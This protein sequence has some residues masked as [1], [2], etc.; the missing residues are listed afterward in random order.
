MT[1][2]DTIQPGDAE[3]PVRGDGSPNLR[4][5]LL[6]LS[7]ILLAICSMS[8]IVLNLIHSVIRNDLR[9]VLSAVASSTS[10]EFQRQAAEKIRQVESLAGSTSVREAVSR[11]L[12][13]DPARSQPEKDTAEL[14]NLL[15]GM[16]GTGRFA[17]FCVVAADGSILARSGALSAAES[18]FRQLLPAYRKTNQ[19]GAG[20][21]VLLDGNEGESLFIAAA[22][23]TDNQDQYLGWLVFFNRPAAELSTIIA[24]N[25]LGPDGAVF[26]FDRGGRLLAAGLYDQA[27]GEN[28]HPGWAASGNPAA[29]AAG[30]GPYAAAGASGR[31]GE[32]ISLDLDGYTGIRGTE[33][34]GA[35]TW[36][37]SPGVGVAVELDLAAAYQ[38]YRWI[39]LLVLTAFGLSV[40][41]FVVLLA[42][43]AGSRQ[44]ALARAEQAVV[45]NERLQQEIELRGKLEKIIQENDEYIRS[46]VSSIMDGVITTDSSGRIE[47]LNPRAEK[48]FGY[49]DFELAG[50]KLSVLAAS[51]YSR[52]LTQRLGRYARDGKASF[53]GKAIE[54][55]G[56]RKSGKTFPVE[57]SVA[58]MKLAG[59]G[60]LVA[61]ARDITKHKRLEKKLREQSSLDGLTR[62]A[63][64]RT[65]DSTLAHE[66]KRASR[67]GLPLGLIML[68]IDFFK[69]YNDSL[70]HQAGDQCLRQV[71]AV[72]DK[73]VRRPGDLAARYGGEE[74]VALLPETSPRGTSY[75]AEKIRE[76]VEAL[77]MVHPASQVSA[78][79][80]VSLGEVNFVPQ[81][82]QDSSVLVSAADQ[83]LYE[84]KHNGRNRVIRARE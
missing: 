59:T 28:P 66:W 53:I 57:L 37:P 79:V 83:A 70:G 80:T 81:R 84:A 20:R 29:T 69:N 78:V 33:V 18:A 73:L 11:S 56:R 60:K 25:P 75:L 23:L 14:E 46:V 26:F 49:R 10:S 27:A 76:Q 58:E 74:F 8:W 9:E 13:P 42:R 63:N 65:F 50:E 3:K 77:G 36:L 82:S 19:P 68:D 39:R 41:L 22:P 47:T 5:D 31:T 51:P 2:P 43:L 30:S 6:L 24:V 45:A 7:V 67:H 61:I 21:F 1:S 15:A 62:I 34:V 32:Q 16:L 72:L 71:A 52:Q 64:R 17:G 38:S 35:W 44:D 40:L 54:I 4:L 12:E 48:M 55:K